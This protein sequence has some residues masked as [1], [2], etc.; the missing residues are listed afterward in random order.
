M[1][2]QAKIR[3]RELE[4]R[5]YMARR[6]LELDAVLT[7]SGEKIV[8]HDLSVNGLLIETSRELS[9]GEELVIAIAGRAPTSATV[10][11]NSGYFYGC[12]FHFSVPKATVSAALL[13]S[14]KLRTDPPA[15]FKPDAGPIAASDAEEESSFSQDDRYALRVRV[16]A[17]LGLAGGSWAL[18]GSVAWRLM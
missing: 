13:Q 6:T 14:R 12:E 15:S 5:R 18:L 3:T 17:I 2:A 11:W 10:V 9:H 1:S 7:N 8:V 4:D 16:A